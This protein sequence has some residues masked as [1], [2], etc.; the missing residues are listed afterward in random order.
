MDDWNEEVEEAM[1]AEA[2]N[3]EPASVTENEHSDD[4]GESLPETENVTPAS[5][6]RFEHI[7]LDLIS[8]ADPSIREVRQVSHVLVLAKPGFL[9]EDRGRVSLLPP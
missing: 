2:K 1:A 8:V 7:P 5:K 9:Q 6:C 3:E 4:R